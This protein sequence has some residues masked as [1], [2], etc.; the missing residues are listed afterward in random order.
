MSDEGASA[1]TGTGAPDTNLTGPEFNFKEHLSPDLATHQSMADIKDLNGLAKSYIS[2]Q[3]MIGQQRLPLPP[4]DADAETMG[5]F[6]DSIG[7][8]QGTAD[9]GYGYDFSKT[10]DL[11]EGLVKDEKMEAFFRKAMHE[12]GL[13]QKQAEGLY[14]SQVEYMGQAS[15]QGQ[16]A[17]A[18]LEKQWDIQVRQDFGL[19]HAEQMDV[20]KQAIEKFGTDELRTYFNESRLGNHPEMIKFAAKVGSAMIE[21][22]NMG[23]G[24][25]SG[26]TQMTPDAA[27]TEI[28]NLQRNPQFMKDYNEQTPGHAE[29]VATMQR[30]HDAAY[31][32]MAE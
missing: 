31:P 19:A 30:L 18:E 13:T 22:G 27:R 5:K 28:A 14:K 16:E 23:E 3:E 12:N 20:A 21:S 25:R 26:G 6:Y 2:G 32:E 17:Q 9:D 7:R 11:P 29:A 4:A 1:D 10:G 24:G 15:K 8:P